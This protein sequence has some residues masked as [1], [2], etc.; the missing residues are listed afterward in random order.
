[1]HC[2]A[3]LQDH[4]TQGRTYQALA[5]VSLGVGI[6]ALAAGVVLWVI[7]LPDEQPS[8]RSAS[9]TRLSGTF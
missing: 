8:A 7:G 1:M 2:A 5:N 4:A 6:A 9:A 3:A